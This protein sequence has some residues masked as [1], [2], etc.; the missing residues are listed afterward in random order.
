MRIK[1]PAGQRAAKQKGGGTMP[2]G[3][4]WPISRLM[5]PEL[6]PISSPL[7]PGGKCSSEIGHLNSSFPAR[8]PAAGRSLSGRAVPR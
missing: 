3:H 6:C 1:A 7:L 8:N 2:Q 4:A 5:T